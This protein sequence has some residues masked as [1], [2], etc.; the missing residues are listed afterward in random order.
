MKHFA[1]C[2]LF[3]M[4][5]GACQQSDT[6]Q[7]VDVKFAQTVSTPTQLITSGG[8]K[9]S[10]S[11]I[12]S[13]LVGP[14]LKGED[15]EWSINPNGTSVSIFNE[16]GRA[17]PGEWQFSKNQYCR[18]SQDA[19]QFRCSDVYALGPVYRYSAPKSPGKLAPW[20]VTAQ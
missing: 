17:V 10:Q 6:A 3:P 1:L 20:Y 18:R 12:K 9:L 8:R 4:A 16:T 2:I 14:L 13:E 11:D 7:T 15:F 5:L 19:R